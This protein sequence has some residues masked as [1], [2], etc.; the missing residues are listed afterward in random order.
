VTSAVWSKSVA[1]GLLVGGL[2]GVGAG[3]TP[4]FQGAGR[5]PADTESLFHQGPRID[6]DPAGRPTVAEL[7]EARV[8]AARQYLEAT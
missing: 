4:A 6:P 7:A 1:V 5:S 2:L 8:R 3:R